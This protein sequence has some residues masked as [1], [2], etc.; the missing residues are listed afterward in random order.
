MYLSNRDIKLAI[1][2][3][4]PIVDPGPETRNP[5]DV[6]KEA[7]SACLDTGHDPSGPVVDVNKPVAFGKG[8]RT[9]SDVTW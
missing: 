9:A 4:K 5:E 1:D 3:G 7:R 8:G 6:I 2:R